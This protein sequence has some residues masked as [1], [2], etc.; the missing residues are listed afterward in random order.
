[1]RII[2]DDFTYGGYHIER[3]ECELPQINNLEDLTEDMI[4]EHI[5]AHLEDYVGFN[6]SFYCYEKA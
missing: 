3:W 6:D 4:Y 5:I 1:M 2:L